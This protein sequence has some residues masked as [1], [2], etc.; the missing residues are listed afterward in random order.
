MCLVLHD[1]GS[2]RYEVHDE[3]DRAWFEMSFYYRDRT[4]REVAFNDIWNYVRTRDPEAT[5][6]GDRFNFT[7]RGQE[8]LCD[9][10]LAGHTDVFCK[11][12][13]R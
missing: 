2:T 3:D 5:H 1:V 12:R 7:H 4:A 10:T 6:T 9:L 11:V 13:L 8:G